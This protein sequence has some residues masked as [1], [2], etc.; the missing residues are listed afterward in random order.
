[1][2]YLIVGLGNIGEEYRHTRHNIGFDILDAFSEA[3][4]IVFQTRRYGDVAEYSLKGRQ[5]ILLKP[6]TFMNSSGLAVRYWMQKEKIPLEN[7]LILVDDLS[8]PVGQIRLRADGSNA[9][10]NGLGSICEVLGTDRYARLRMGIGRDFP[11]G[12]QVDYVL[13]RWSD[14]VL[15]QLKPRF[16]L[17]CDAVRAFCLSGIEFAMNQYN[18]KGL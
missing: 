12:G 3:S 7:V 9:G 15:A 4:N 14:E 6:S 1:M 5:L 13:G 16:E 11:Q 17:A 2:K 10:H 8:L 18:R